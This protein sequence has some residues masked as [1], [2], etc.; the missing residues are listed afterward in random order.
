MIPKHVFLGTEGHEKLRSGIKKLAGAVKSTLGPSGRPVILEDEHSVGGKR[1]TKDGVTVAK[2][3]NLY[4]PVENIAVSIMKEA[5]AQTAL[6]A[7]DGT[8]TS[9]VLTEAILD[10]SEN[11]LKGNVTTIV[12]HIK[13]YAE[14]VDDYLKKKSKKVTKGR[15]QSVATIS[16]NN[17]PKLGKMIA[18]MFKKVKVVSIENS[19]TEETYTEIID[20][21]K[22]DRGYTTYHMVNNHDRETCELD[23]PYILLTDM[24]ITDLTGSLEDVIRECI[25]KGRP[26]LIVGRM[27][28]KA[29]AT[30][31]YNVQKGTIKGCHVL[32]PDFGY[33]QK[34][35]MRDLAVVMDANYYSEETGDGMHNITPDGL[36]IAKRVV[37]SKDRTI[38][39]RDEA[40]A[41]EPLQE[42]LAELKARKVN[43]P[44]D[45][46]DRDERI[47]NI[48]GG[49]GI[50]HVGAESPIEQKEKYDRVDDAVRAVSAALEEGILAG[51]GISLLDSI[52]FIGDD[53]STE[54]ATAAIDILRNAL[55]APFDQ[56]MRNAGLES[57]E[58]ASN[59]VQH[60][61]GYGYDLKNHKYGDMIEM[62]VIDPTLVTRSALK[63]AVSVATTILS[64]EA[65]VTNMR[66]GDA[67]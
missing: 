21:M 22:F 58:V 57:K 9:I 11:N 48:E 50:I 28:P 25:Q 46:K 36:G 24:E 27:S 7:G 10:A 65:I 35:M 26:L 66:E 53:I 59:M 62:G 19:Q 44:R 17:D 6:M 8:T 16:A 1:I 38:I 32:P 47:A 5:S 64:S 61:Y 12:K 67:S 13:D 51:G 43:N 42:R 54:E 29:M 52:E 30:F 45:K 34:E 56:I 49:I 23:R 4:D 33:R 60:P 18:D 20:G 2:A 39:Y 15:L 63:N 40:L 41:Q 3:I 37:I 14:Q 31:A 55:Y